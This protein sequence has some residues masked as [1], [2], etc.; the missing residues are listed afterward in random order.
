MVLACLMFL[1]ITSYLDVTYRTLGSV[2]SMRL[3]AN[4]RMTDIGP[5]AAG[6]GLAEGDRVLG[7]GS[8]DVGTLMEFRS[9]LS[10]YAPGENA[11]L[12]VERG[13]ATLRVPLA[14]HQR[15]L[16]LRSAFLYM[17]VV[18]F[19]LMGCLVAYQQPRDRTARL[20]CLAS[21]TLG[22][23]FTLTRQDHIALAALQYMA[24]TTAPALAIHFF[25]VFPRQRVLAQ[26]PKALLIYLP[27]LVL[28]VC[29]LAALSHSARAGTGIWFNPTLEALVNID[30]A[31]LVFAGVVGTS[32]VVRSYATVA[33]A[34]RRRQ[35]QWILFGLCVSVAIGAMD[36]FLTLSRRQSELSASL[37]LA[38]VMLVPVTFTLAIL[39]YHLLDVEFVINRS[40]V[41]G[42]L[43]S[44]LASIYVLLVNFL[45]GA[46]RSASGRSGSILVLFV[47]SLVVG[48]LFSPLRSRIQRLID[49]IFF[50]QQT[51]FR[52]ALIGWS[53]ELATRIRFEDLAE[54]LLSD[55]PD[56][57]KID[58]VWLLAL[59]EDGQDLV[60][61]PGVSSSAR[62]DIVQLTRASADGGLY[63]VLV[64]LDDSGPIAKPSHSGAR[65][66][67]SVI[68]AVWK[69]QGIQVIVPL[70]CAN[71]LVGAYMLGEKRSGDVYLR[72]EIDLLRT[73]GNQAA[74]AISNASLY[75]DVRALSED[76]EKKV[77]KR[78]NELRDSFATVA[79]EL[80]TPI[81]AIQGY[82]SFLLEG[83]AGPLTD[84]QSG[85]LRTMRKSS[86]R[87]QRLVTDLSDV[88][89]IDSGRLTIR[90]EELD[91]QSLVDE[92]LGALT[93]TIEEKGLHT[94]VA[95]DPTAENVHG[96]PQRIVQILSNL[97]GNACRFTPPGG[98][99]GIRAV[100]GDS[101][102]RIVV[103][104]T[105]IGIPREEQQR[106]F[107]R[108]FR[109]DDP[110]V[111][112]Q[113]GT[114]LGLSIARSLVEMH[115]GELW[116]ESEPGKGSAFTFTLPALLQT[117]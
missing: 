82:T 2:T 4:L 47:S 25:L 57:L 22:L 87:L 16:T 112:E 68:P 111:R 29:T 93:G 19:F 11:L 14:V 33:R 62:D 85:Y 38:G 63:E 7:I 10:E 3:D 61:P 70:V 96:D 78:T 6:A 114:G 102:V 58:R 46:V 26:W 60:P 42:L 51:S 81:T 108:F 28:A 53:Q 73:L 90:P 12:L 45:A 74:I 55:V 77:E 65:G 5:E 48:L 40:M 105:G 99:V 34:T 91:L 115:G 75:E 97:I 69:D 44:V 20:F 113:A 92:A 9:A 31:Y 106:I 109:G 1:G 39:R 50:R 18:L 15:G 86:E 21:L 94:E 8:Q 79:H 24:L 80:N 67:W 30:F 88:T 43:T 13:D 83:S 103:E 52:Q 116:V 64:D 17:V 37:L 59:T 110:Y 49:N 71:R 32:L 54:V 36:L 100:L 117:D 41:Y 76:L 23:Y 104:D 35:L 98:K 72:Q 95:I 84:R 107:D 27:G 56:L 66:P 89:R 101:M